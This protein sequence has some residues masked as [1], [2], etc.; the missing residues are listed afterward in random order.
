MLILEN[1]G[2]QGAWGGGSLRTPSDVRGTIFYDWNNT[3]YYCDPSSTSNLNTVTCNDWYYLNGSA[4]MYW[5]SY[6]RGFRSPEGEGNSYGTVTT[7][8]SG[9]N[10]WNGWGIGSRHVFMSTGGDNVGVHDNSRGWI[11]YWNGS[12]TTFDF[13]YTQ[14]ANSARS[15]IFYDNN[16]TGYY[17]DPASTSRLNDTHTNQSYTSGWF[18]NYSNNTGLYNQNTTQHWSSKDNGYWDASSTN[19]VSSIRFWTGG[20]I[21]SLRGYVFANNSNE[22][23][24]QDNAGDWTMRTDSS[25]NCFAHGTL[26]SYNDVVAYYSDERLKTKTGKIENALDKVMSLEAFTYTHNELAVSLGYQDDKEQQIG[27]SAQDVQKI[28]PELVTLAAFDVATD[29]EGSKYSKSGENYLTIKY[30]RLVPVL[31]EAIKEQQ[32]QIDEL[33][34]KLG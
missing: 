19:T 7:V 6:S 4:G 3:G 13:G 20:H 24:F 25:S 9:R 31:I 15:P 27:L 30:D 26:Y 18:R 21:S 12:Y 10:G 5:N 14:F 23:G 1:G 2:F 32:K 28:A 17:C 34:A 29:E 33:K 8:G 11:W 22:I 16:D